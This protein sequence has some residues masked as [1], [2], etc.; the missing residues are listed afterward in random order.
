MKLYLNPFTKE[1]W[2]IR[3]EFLEVVLAVGV[4]SIL[5]LFGFFLGERL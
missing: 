3:R 4:G 5:F 1:A 2:Q